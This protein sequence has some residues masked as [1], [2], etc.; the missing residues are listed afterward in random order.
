MEAIAAAEHVRGLLAF[1]AVVLAGGGARD[2]DRRQL[3]RHGLL[4][5]RRFPGG[6]NF[7]WSKFPHCHN[8]DIFVS[9]IEIFKFSLVPLNL[10]FIPSLPQPLVFR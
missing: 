9:T 1:E 10:R 7:S 6:N 2:V 3:P 4:Q 8:L 5:Q